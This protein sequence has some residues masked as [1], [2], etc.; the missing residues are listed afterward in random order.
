MMPMKYDEH[1]FQFPCILL[2]DASLTQYWKKTFPGALDSGRVKLQD[3]SH[4]IIPAFP[5]DEIFEFPKAT[6]SSTR[7]HRGMKTSQSS[8][9]A[10][11]SMT[12]RTNTLEAFASRRRAQDAAGHPRTADSVHLGRT[13]HAQ[14]PGAEL[15]VPPKSLLPNWGRAGS[16]AHVRCYIEFIWC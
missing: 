4:S 12:G 6:V 1:Q 7:S 11:F 16:M 8:F 13:R 2:P 3:P 5:R 14:I 9:Y 15:S 10:R